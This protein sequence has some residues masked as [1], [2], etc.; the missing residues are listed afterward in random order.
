MLIISGML[1]AESCSASGL[2]SEDR[3][4]AC[5]AHAFW[6]GRGAIGAL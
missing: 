5:P 6:Q 3:P 2:V 4:P 1:F